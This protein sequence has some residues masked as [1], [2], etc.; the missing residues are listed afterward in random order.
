MLNCCLMI[1]N[2]TVFIIYT[3]LHLVSMQYPFGQYDIVIF[4]KNGLNKKILTDQRFDDYFLNFQ[5][6]V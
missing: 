5:K 4:D 2:G 3:G 6:M 1:I